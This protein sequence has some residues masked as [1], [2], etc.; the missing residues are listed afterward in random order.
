MIKVSVPY[1]HDPADLSPI[2]LAVLPR[3]ARPGED[4]WVPAYRD[5]VDGRRVVWARFEDPA[6]VVWLRTRD[7]QRE[8]TRL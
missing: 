4:D 2:H 6:G 3:G 8:V 5:T 1:E 7:G